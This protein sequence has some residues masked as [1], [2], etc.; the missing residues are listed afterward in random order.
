ML[1]FFLVLTIGIF[2]WIL[3]N[4]PRMRRSG[5]RVGLDRTSMLIL[6]VGS[7]LVFFATGVVYLTR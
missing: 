3:A 1:T 7:V 2:V 5:L 6:G 4:V